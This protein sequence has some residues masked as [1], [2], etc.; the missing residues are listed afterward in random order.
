MKEID[1]IKL[2]IENKNMPELKE[3]LKDTSILE[4][5]IRRDEFDSILYICDHILTNE[6][7]GNLFDIIISY[8][9][10]N[11]MNATSIEI[12][13]KI[14]LHSKE[15]ALLNKEHIFHICRY[16][17][18]IE[19]IKL[20]YEI[21]INTD[22]NEFMIKSCLFSQKGMFDFLIE[23]FNF[24]SE[25]INR[26][27]SGAINSECFDACTN[28]PNQIYIIRE[29]IENMGADVNQ[30]GLGWDYLYLDCFQNVPTAAIYFYTKDF[31]ID[32]INN[33]EFWSEMLEELFDEDEKEHYM[34][35]LI[36]IKNS[37]IYKDK[38]IIIFDGLDRPELANLISN[39]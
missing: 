13:K 33:E 36:D 26:S 16:D 31:N 34:N 18:N 7:I 17:G 25:T 8:C 29:L 22:W 39:K 6:L 28:D 10:N 30:N 23:K 27:L 21:E 20:L 3:M 5:L 12:L 11:H 1:D 4:C 15:L 37:K 38:L 2:A 35:A 9:G 19:L 24:N 14:K 32:S